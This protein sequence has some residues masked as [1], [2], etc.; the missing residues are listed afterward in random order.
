MQQIDL[1]QLDLNLLLVFDVLLEECHVTRTAKRLGRTQS[2]VSHALSR[3]RDQLGD[4][5]LVRVGGEMRP[6]PRALRLAPE[7]RRLLKSIERV[8]SYEIEWTAH[9]STRVF[10]L[11][12]PDFIAASLPHLLAR[13]TAEAPQTRLE[14]LPPFEGW[15]PSVLD[16]GCDL[17][18]AP[19][20]AVSHEGLSSEPI[21]DMPW[22][23][24]GR[25]G[26]PAF[27]GW[28]V[29]SWLNYPHVQIRTRGKGNSAV[30]AA[31]EARGLAR[32]NG[33]LLSHFLLAPSLLSASELL[34]TVPRGVL[35]EMAGRFGLVSMPCPIELPEMTLGLH[36][37]PV[38]AEEP[39][40]VW[41]KGLVAD[42]MQHTLTL[43]EG[44]PSSRAQ[45]GVS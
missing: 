1:H 31:L 28:G 15:Q 5:I 20:T 18:L 27:E 4:P 21:S 6:T 41:F 43:P 34:L 26:H 37:S 32:L 22:R 9:T 2:A 19:M 36:Q 35:A 10:T 25:A 45:A 38:F 16:G 42:A 40:M 11:M 33:P 12:A 8:L 17:A 23:V 29:D 3:L 30:E 44:A 7:V 24:Y 14:M 39:A 13:M